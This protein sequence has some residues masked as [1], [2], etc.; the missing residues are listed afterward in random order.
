MKI[1]SDEYNKQEWTDYLKWLASSKYYYHLDDGG[2]DGSGLDDIIWQSTT[3]TKEDLCT[4]KENHQKL[5]SLVPSNDWSELEDCYYGL[6][7]S[8]E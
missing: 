4:L 1:L 5:V 8:G 6:L 2:E 7:V 3:I